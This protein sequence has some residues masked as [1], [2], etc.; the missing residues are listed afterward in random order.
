MAKIVAQWTTDDKAMQQ[1]LA[2]QQREIAKLREEMRKTSDESTKGSE[3]SNKGFE[4]G[5]TNLAGM[6]AGYVSLRTVI[7]AV[8]QE[9]ERQLRLGKE[10]EQLA[11]P[12]AV[13]SAALNMNIVGLTSAEKTMVHR[14]VGDFVGMGVSPA[15]ARNAIGGAISSKGNLTPAE[16]LE[17]P[18]AA[19]KALPLA[20][21]GP[22]AMQMTQGAQGLALATGQTDP[23]ANFGFL[24]SVAQQASITDQKYIA[25]NVTRAVLGPV[26]PGVEKGGAAPETAGAVFATL[27]TAMNDTTGD[28]SR[29]ATI[30]FFKKMKAFSKAKEIQGTPREVIAQLQADPALAAE[31]IG[32]GQGFEAVAQGA[33]TAI[34]DPNSPVW[35]TYQ[36]NIATFP[37][38]EGQR[39]T[40]REIVRSQAETASIQDEIFYQQLAAGQAFSAEKHSQRAALQAH[41]KEL[42]IRVRAEDPTTSLGFGLI[43]D[44]RAGLTVDPEDVIQQA[45]ETKNLAIRGEGPETAESDARLDAVIDA[46][47]IIGRKLD[48]LNQSIPIPSPSE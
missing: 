24:F 9:Q 42:L 15:D 44:L 14:A 4:K 38:V 20:A 13:A 46:A 27:S 48:R 37:N 47:N 7:Q 3:K 41:L 10:L 23:E 30:A 43:N 34:L 25:Q 16:A 1:A 18:R 12:G 33:I 26:G 28:Q 35:Q 22:T 19:F 45:M 21:Q 11:R 39:R 5:I 8:T 40:Y 17:F 29:T 31:F 32:D 6:V 36:E 2:R